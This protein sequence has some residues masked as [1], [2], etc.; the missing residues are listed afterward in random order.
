[1]K[2]LSIFV[3]TALNIPAY[4]QIYD[5]IKNEIISGHLKKNNR[6]PSSRNLAKSLQYSRSTI[7]MAYE[8]L[9]AE[10][11]IET[12]PRSGYYVS[13]IEKN[14]QEKE[15]KTVGNYF[16]FEKRENYD[17]NF[18]PDG[19]ETEHF[20]YN[21][22]RKN[23][24]QIM[25][26]DNDEL[27][28]SGDSRGDIGLRTILSEYLR[29]SRGVKASPERIILGAGNESLLAILNLLFDRENVFAMEDPAYQKSYKIIQGFGRRVLSVGM[30]EYGINI[31]KLSD[32]DADIAYVTPSHQYPLGIVMSVKRRQELL[33][34]AS[35]SE[36]RYII[37]DDYDSELRYK[38]KPIP[39]LQGIDKSNKVIYIGTFSKSVSP[40]IRMSYMVLPKPLYIKY[41]NKLTFFSNTVSRID[42]KLMELFIT[43]GGFERHLNR[44]RTIYKNKHDVMLAELKKWRNTKISGE[45]AGAH[46]LVEIDNGMSE[47]KLV[48]LAGKAGIKVYP[49]SEY[50]IDN[51][52]TTRPVILLGYARLNSEGIING[53]A[54]LKKVWNISEK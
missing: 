40:A 36:Q 47:K 17:I 32:T 27:F 31:S 15:E 1:M 5:Y 53:L 49:M 30:D 12:R 7:L 11:Y 22:W 23:M 25:T 34:W 41:M 14:F 3:N 51:I 9:E 45:N 39:A 28:N 33:N 37:E 18:S 16:S 44:M 13:E 43:S 29:D 4:E 52:L 35:E 54:I 10:G 24:R 42:Q 26:T 21:E 6:L 50:Y 19:I 20:P 38:G 48:E 46:M 8:Q 2:D